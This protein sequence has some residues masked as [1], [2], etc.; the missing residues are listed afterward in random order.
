MQGEWRDVT[1][2]EL[3]AEIRKPGPVL[4]A[5]IMGSDSIMVEA[6]KGDLIRQID[7][8]WLD[9]HQTSYGP[10]ARINRDEH[11]LWIWGC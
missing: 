6:K 10:I 7:D 3:I 2:N 1:P 9:N 4:V 5:A 8:V 11:G